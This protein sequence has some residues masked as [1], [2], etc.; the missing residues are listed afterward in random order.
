MRAVRSSHVRRLIA[1][2]RRLIAALLA[3]A[4]VV[5]VAL[6]VRPPQ[7][8]EILAAARD[9]PGGRLSASDVMIVRLPPGAVPDGVFH[10]G[11]S[12]TGRVVAG[13]VRRG[14]PL[15]DVRLLSEGLL[16]AH[17][18]GMV[19][20]PVRI[21]DA[22]AARL[23]SPGDVVDVLAAFEDPTGQAL[24]VAREVTVVTRTASRSTE[25]A[26]LVLATTTDQAAQLAQAQSHGRLSI[27]LHAR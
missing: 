1:R 27:A 25:G 13:P 18:P 24:T 12:V 2:R 15:T 3:A 9:L 26:L 16:A 11:S 4:A 17:G 23:L 14:E 19:A 10:S 21:A 22:D 5:C 6:S 7:G 20:A 8:V